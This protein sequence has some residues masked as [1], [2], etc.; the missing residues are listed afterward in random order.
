MY[1]ANTITGLHK[2]YFAKIEFY[3]GK[4]KQKVYKNQH[5]LKQPID[6]WSKNTLQY[7]IVTKISS[8]T[9]I[10]TF[11]SNTGCNTEQY[12]IINQTTIAY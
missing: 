1:L 2:T 8:E 3:I 10:V 9:S 5:W 7:Y 11:K 4:K 6:F 12:K